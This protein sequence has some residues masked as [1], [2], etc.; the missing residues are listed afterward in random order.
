VCTGLR[1]ELD[2]VVFRSHLE[3]A[4]TNSSSTARHEL[5]R[6]LRR[7]MRR[8]L[9]DR[10][11][12]PSA[13]QLHEDFVASCAG[14]EDS[15]AF[16]Q[17]IVPKLLQ[18]ITRLIA[19]AK[20]DT[21]QPTVSAE[22]EGKENIWELQW[23]DTD[24]EEAHTA[25]TQSALPAPMPQS[26]TPPP[27]PPP[28][29]AQLPPPPFAASSAAAPSP[30]AAAPA[31]PPPPP[32]KMAQL[33]PVPF[34]VDKVQEQ[35]QPDAIA[36]VE[37]AQDGLADSAAPKVKPTP[38]QEVVAE[39]DWAALDQV[40]KGGEGPSMAELE[41]DANAFLASQT[42]DMFAQPGKPARSHGTPPA[43]D[44]ARAAEQQDAGAGQ[45][46]DSL[47]AQ[48]SFRGGGGASQ[49]LEDW[50]EDDE[51]QQEKPLGRSEPVVMPARRPFVTGDL[52]V[53]GELGR[54]PL[55]NAEALVDLLIPGA[56]LTTEG[57]LGQ[58]S[59]EELVLF[60]YSL[61]QVNDVANKRLVTEL[62][63]RDEWRSICTHRKEYLQ[64]LDGS[65]V[66]PLTH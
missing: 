16:A 3:D 32:P 13:V 27:P 7:F 25:K 55:L 6:I 47:S 19:A 17:T 4:L 33:P 53:I 51:Q 38:G 12:A 44:D 52:R 35:P 31:P 30:S 57:L 61:D 20:S 50:A 56:E 2:V 5:V 34:K 54:T 39:T 9:H 11:R 18:Q 1:E 49:E 36:E 15:R 23:E 40:I 26:A 46:S 65:L 24:T 10:L 8:A 22:V 45:G 21:P 41:A 59:D 48:Y 29:V 28:K 58:M 63:Q 60:A 14:Q 42:T 37:P 66:G 62:K 64:L 43:E